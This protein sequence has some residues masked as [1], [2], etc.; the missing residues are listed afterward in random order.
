MASRSFDIAVIGGG[1]YGCRTALAL[2]KK[3]LKVALLEQTDTL[4]GR[5]SR[6]NQ[7]RIHNGYHY[8][9][10]LMTAMGSHKNYERFKEE[11]KSCVLDD[12][13]HLYAIAGQGSKI[14]AH[15]FQSFC[16][17]VGIPLQEAN[18]EQKSLFDFS[19]IDNVFVAQEVGVNTL[20]L[21]NVLTKQ[22]E[23]DSNIEVFY[24]FQCEK[25]HK[26]AQLIHVLKR[27]GEEV[28]ASK[29]VFIATYAGANRLLLASE[30]SPL[31]LKFELA[32]MAL[33]KRP[34]MLE[35]YSITIMDGP[36]F[37]VMPFG[38]DGL[39]TLSHVRYTPHA[40]TENGKLDTYQALDVYK[41]THDSH[42]PFM[43]NDAARYLPVM[44]DAEYV[45]SLFEVK[46]IPIKNELDDGRPILMLEHE[47]VIG[48]GDPFIVSVLGSKLDT[49]YEWEY[50]IETKF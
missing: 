2:S 35:N 31:P 32:E 4:L 44:R 36:F 48:G 39:A 7:S 27:D 47:G 50:I 21:S 19:R 41:H 15:Q 13:E 23:S 45:D 9:R 16:K 12:F 14:N 30:L 49:I 26:S 10:S 38:A 46:A 5:A 11:Y 8:P 40:S 3:G 24:N 29:G 6:Y 1:L 43:R 25:V 34:K 37:S 17:T 42:F 22:V 18:K 20:A 33:I 28:K